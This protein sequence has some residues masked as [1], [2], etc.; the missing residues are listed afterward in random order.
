MNLALLVGVSKYSNLK[1]LLACQADVELMTK[2]LKATNKYDDFLVISENKKA[3]EVKA[4]ITEWIKTYE[5]KKD[6]EEIFFYLTG[7]GDFDGDEFYFPLSDFTEEHRNQT[8]LTNS[9]I[10]KWLRSLS[11]LLAVKVVDACRS[12]IQYVK[13]TEQS[14]DTYLS[15]SAV[16]PGFK[17]CYFMF[18]S[19]LDQDSRQDSKLSYFTR[20]FADAIKNREPGKIRFQ[21]IADYIADDF[22]RDSR[23]K[24]FFITQGNNTEEFCE[25]TP[26]FKAL[27]ALPAPTIQ[28]PVNTNKITETQLTNLLELVKANEKEYCTEKE[29]WGLFEDTK[30]EIENYKP[31]KNLDDLYN[32]TPEFIQNLSTLPPLEVIGEW[33]EQTQDTFFAEPVYDKP[34]EYNRYYDLNAKLLESVRV[35][36]KYERSDG[37]TLKGFRSTADLEY[38]GIRVLAVPKYLSIPQAECTV[39]FVISK[40]QIRFFYYQTLYRDVNWQKREPVANLKWR[41]SAYKLK[42]Q[43]GIL[44]F[45]K[46]ILGE[47][48]E[49][50]ISQIRDKL[51]V[52]TDPSQPQP[53]DKTKESNVSNK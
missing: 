53:K 19:M 24:P 22:R 29:V 15:K 13:N 25:I 47:F 51:D 41:T 45:F 30:K 23:Q 43:T 42:D 28:L 10:D 27:F 40:T 18:S 5:G 36:S 16:Q 21:D 17:K 39:V 49:W 14:F 46:K 2:I 38:L 9:E 6:I 26:S 48:E 4:N 1:D 20:S 37:R 31:T 3:A 8:S 33:L 35:R 52:A 44:N 12:G 50:L 32:I 11:P 7:H 34:V